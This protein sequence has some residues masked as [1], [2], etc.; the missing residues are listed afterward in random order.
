MEDILAPGLEVV[1]DAPKA[2]MITHLTLGYPTLSPSRYYRLQL[3][4]KNCGQVY[5]TPV[6]LTVASASVPA[7]IVE[8]PHV[9]SYDD[10]TTFTLGWSDPP[11][12][13]G[14]AVLYYSVYVD[15]N[16]FAT[17]DAS[18]NIAAITTIS[19]TTIA[20]GGQYKM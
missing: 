15:N 18:Q 20:L 6:F 13:G 19:N 12:S 1:Y 5:S 17:I 4:S 9:V 16:V 8:A 7:Q 11:L 10:A 2:S 3:Q 14:F